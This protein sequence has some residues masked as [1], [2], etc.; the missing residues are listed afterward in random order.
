[1]GA[2]VTVLGALTI[3]PFVAPVVVLLAPSI[4]RP[5]HQRS[6]GPWVLVGAGAVVLWIAWLNRH[7][8]GQYMSA[9]LRADRDSPV[10]YS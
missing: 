7:G 9:R 3:G 4:G 8:P 6:A 5:E 10:V 1:M 2:A